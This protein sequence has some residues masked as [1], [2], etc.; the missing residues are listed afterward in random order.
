LP[1]NPQHLDV[2]ERETE[3]MGPNVNKVYVFKEFKKLSQLYQA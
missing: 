1:E 3:L 2:S